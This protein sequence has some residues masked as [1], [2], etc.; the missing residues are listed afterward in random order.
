M[1]QLLSRLQGKSSEKDTRGQFGSV[2]LYD[3]G[4][5]GIARPVDTETYGRGIGVDL[6][7]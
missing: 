1:L 7:R 5:G 4:F 2:G 3:A 6:H